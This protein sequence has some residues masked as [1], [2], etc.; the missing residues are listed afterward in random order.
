MTEDVESFRRRAREWIRAN[1]QLA[2][3]AGQ[4]LRGKGDEK[5][6]A[7]VAHERKLQRML[8]DAGFAGICVP[9]EYDGQG[10]TSAHQRAFND[11]LVGYEYPSRRQVPPMTPCMAVLLEFGTEEQKKRHVPAILKGEEVWMQLLSEP[12]GGSDVASALMSAV[13]EGEE[14][15]LN[16]SKIWTSGAWW[17]DWGLV[18]ARTNWDAP[19]S[20]GC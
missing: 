2:T 15:V 7:E 3:G 8:F 9:R 14:W 6:L 18:L 5:D 1:L 19:R 11:E 17:A 12:S 16:G 20:D 4:T 13:R 10:L